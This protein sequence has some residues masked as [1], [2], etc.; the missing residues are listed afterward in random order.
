MKVLLRSPLS[1]Y[2]GYGNDGIGLAQALMRF[3]ADVYIQP[4]AVDAPLPEDVAQLFTKP[5]QAPFDLYINHTDPMALTCPPEIENHV[6]VSVGW[7]MWEYSNLLN[8]EKKP[9]KTLRERLKPFDLLLGYSDLDLDCFAPYFDGPIAIRQGGYDPQQWPELERDWNEENFYF[10]MVGVLSNRKAPF[11]AVEAFVALSR[12][13]EDFRKHARLGLK[14]TAPGLSSRMED[15]Y[16]NVRIFYEVWTQDEVRDFYQA[17]HVLLSPSR[18]EGKNMPAL[19][20]M[21]TGGV[22]IAT[23][24]AGHKQW[25]NPT[26]SYALDYKLEPMD[27]YQPETFNATAD[28]E[29][30]KKLML[31]VFRN[32]DEARTKGSIAAG[33]IPLTHSWDRVVEDLFQKIKDNVPEKG[34]RLWHLAQAARAQSD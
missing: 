1:T 7:T 8:M 5:L 32:R 4:M 10:C 2:T 3:G 29:H 11:A 17:N 14:T 19:E 23:N 34:E 12:E 22:V 26:Y 16:P 31:H 21:S 27:I 25:L 13:H 6:G 20:F 33:V 30:L 9:R 28:I 15:A 24:Y 18:G